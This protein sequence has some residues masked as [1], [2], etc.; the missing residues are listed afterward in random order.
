MNARLVLGFATVYGEPAADD[1]A[2]FTAEQFARFTADPLLM[3]YPAILAGHETPFE[4]RDRLGY[5]FAFRS[6]TGG[7]GVPDGLLALGVFGESPAAVAMAEHVGS[8][9]SDWGLSI[10]ATDVSDA[11]DGSDLWVGEV[12]L[13]KRPGVLSSRVLRV[14]ESCADLWD[15]LTDSPMPDLPNRPTQ[16]VYG[17]AVVVG[18]RI[19]RESWQEVIG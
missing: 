8:A 6:V 10:G 12:G 16:T 11:H 3:G 15:L 19:I 7:L 2:V 9:P 1:G 5:W 4:P 17:Q 18:N 14:G 13:T